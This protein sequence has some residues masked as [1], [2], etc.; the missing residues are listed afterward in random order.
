MT[1]RKQILGRIPEATK[2]A[3]VIQQA[4]KDF[5][6]VVRNARAIG[7]CVHLAVGDWDGDGEIV[8]ADVSID[9]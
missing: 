7:F 9:F 2:E 8:A 3:K 6:A 4:V 5:N 1:K